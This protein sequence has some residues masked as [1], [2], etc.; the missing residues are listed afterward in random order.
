MK[1][2]LVMAG[3][4]LAMLTACNGP[5]ET[6][7]LTLSGLNPQDFEVSIDSVD[8]HLFTLKN[9]NGMEVCITNFGGRIVSI[10][11]P[12]KE[13]KMKDVVLGF[14]SIG[15]YQRIPSDFGAAIGR[16]ANRINQGKITVA[17]K[18]IQ[19][20]T[21][22][23]GHTLHGGPNGWQYK[24]YEANQVDSTTL[25]LTLVS[26]D[27]D[28]NFPGT[29]EAKVVYTLTEDNAI[30][31]QYEATTDAETVVNLTNHAYFNL[32]GDPTIPVTNDTLYINADK[33]T[34]V[35]ST[36]MTSGAIASVFETPL[37]F[38]KPTTIGERIDETSNEQI[39]NAN[40]Y[41]HNW[42]LNTN[43]DVEQIAACVV[44]PVTGIVLEVY[45]DQPG[46]QVYT[47]NFLD[48]TVVGKGGV[49]YPQRGAICL[50]SQV[51]PDSPNKWVKG[52]KG[53]PNP[54]LKPGETYKHHTVFKFSVQK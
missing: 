31:I 33:F 27:G 25:E 40:G 51:Y 35:D 28:E 4:M 10:M 46:L 22:N 15:Q 7:D 47:G 20:P 3:V 19:L 48:G 6:A 8:C 49:A 42:I 1:K 9:G 11:V 17:G 43:G 2:M 39:K 21:N 32:N 29:V 30:D 5:K 16:Y 26:P 12:D 52:V 38:T 45:T 37:D 44:S 14:D 50:E 36:F 23:Y 13:G 53:W 24:M 18:E 34:P 54:Y 41:D